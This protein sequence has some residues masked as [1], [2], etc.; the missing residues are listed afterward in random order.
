MLDHI[1]GYWISQLIY[2]AARL[3]LADF[4]TAGAMSVED[5]ARQ[6]DVDSRALYRV[7]R[8]LAS[9]GVFAEGEAGV[10][11]LTPLAETLRSDRP[12]SMRDFA[13]MMVEGYNWRSW[14]GLL[15]SVKDEE[16]AFDRLHGM[17]L[18]EY[19]EKHPEYREVFARSMTSISGSENPAIAEGYNF[20]AIDTLVDVGGSQ[21]HLLATILKR[22]PNVQGVLFDLPSVIEQAKQAPFLSDVLPEGRVRFEAGDFFHSVPPG[23]DAYLMKYILH[24][25]NDDQCATILSCCRQAMNPQGR[26]LVVDTVVAPGNQPQWGKLLDINMLVVT[27]G[28]ER[29]EAEFAQLF[30]QAGLRLAAVHPTQCPLSVLEAVRE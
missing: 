19:Y 26:V 27:G 8:A 15:E 3:G 9:V 28:R 7:M 18:F 22:H 25:W 30:Q 12:D 23:G 16:V 29:T 17:A 10:F 1:T 21:G 24:D 11:S 4:L 13:L 2:V 20:S 14:E 5:L 6:A